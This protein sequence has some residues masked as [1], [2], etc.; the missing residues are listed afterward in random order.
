MSDHRPCAFDIA[1]F[2]KN[3]I[4]SKSNSILEHKTRTRATILGICARIIVSCLRSAHARGAVKGGLGNG[5]TLPCSLGRALFSVCFVGTLVCTRN[6]D[7]KRNGGER[8]ARMRRFCHPFTEKTIKATNAFRLHKRARIA[9]ETLP[10]IAQG[11]S[12]IHLKTNVDS[13]NPFF[14]REMRKS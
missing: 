7:F 8:G 1:N 13:R 2:R 6:R 5:N 3:A 9:C 10:F 12:K 14:Q 11:A 4:G